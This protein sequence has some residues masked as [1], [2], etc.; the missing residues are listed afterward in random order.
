M[1]R[2]ITLTLGAGLG[3]DLG[4]NFNLTADVGSVTPS[5]ATKS[6]LTA[7]KSVSVDDAATSVTITS[8]GTCTNAITQTIPCAGGTTTTTTTTQ[9]AICY[10]R[11]YRNDSLSIQNVSWTDC[12]TS[13]Y[14]NEALDPNQS[15]TTYSVLEPSFGPGVTLI[16]G[17][18]VHDCG[19]TTTTTTTEAQTTTTTTSGGG[20]GNFFVINIDGTGQITDVDNGGGGYFYFVS[21]GQYP[22][23][24]GET[25]EGVHSGIT[26][27]AVRVFVSNTSTSGCLV[28]YV[29]T[30]PIDSLAVPYD[31]NYTFNNITFGNGDLVE[32]KYTTGNCP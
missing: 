7:G 22:V 9:A 8:T 5:T 15:V 26:G 23:Y 2:N 13:V 12:C 11:E 29:N 18:T 21:V 24:S 17:P 14:Y 3:A 28:L 30:T 20:S 25:L 27:A 19:T 6:E 4:P 1:A 32:I 10:M 16:S 31:G